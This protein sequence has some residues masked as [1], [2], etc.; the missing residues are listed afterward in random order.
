MDIITIDKKAILN[1]AQEGGQLIFKKEAEEH[2][3]KLLEI[4][5]FIDNELEKVKVQIE[6]AGKSISPDFKGVIGKKVKAIY[7]LFGEKY[8]YDK[9]L[10]EVARPYL[11]EFTVRKVISELVEETVEKTGR[12]PKGIIEKERSPKLSITI[13]KEKIPILL[14][15]KE[16]ND[17][18][19]VDF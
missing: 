1:F 17:K 8:A 12:L 4:K 2:L 11:K 9:T 10:I 6:M 3:L 18:P 13:K 16:K 14:D 19:E 7:R 5:E 15:R